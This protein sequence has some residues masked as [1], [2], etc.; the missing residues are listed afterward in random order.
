VTDADDHG[1][2]GVGP[3]GDDGRPRDEATPDR[4][5]ADAGEDGIALPDF[6]VD[7]FYDV[8]EGRARPLVTATE[9]ASALGC[10]QAESHD[11]L[12]RLAGEGRIESL[13]VETDPVVWYP[14]DWKETQ[15]RERVVVFPRRREAVVDRPSQFTRAQLSQFAHLVDTNREEGY[16][17]RVREAD[18][19]QAPH[20]TFE[21]L[22]R[23]MRQ[24]LGGR[25]DDLEGWVRDQWERARKF[26]LYTHEDGYVVLEAESAELLGNVA[27]PKLE[28]GTLRARISD[29]EA[30]VAE[31]KTAE[32]KRTLYE[33]GYPV[34]DDRHLDEGDALEIDVDLELRPYQHDWVSRFV[35]A[36]SGVL[37]GP[38]GS[39][40]TVAALGVMAA[41][42][43]E[44]LVLVPSR[45]LAEQ[46]R[47]EM[48]AHT[49]LTDEQI[50]L[51]HGGEKTIRPVTV[52]T[53]QTAG[54]DR[55]RMLFDERRWGLIVY[56]EVHHIPSPIHRRSADLQTKHR[57]GL[58]VDGDTILPVRRGGGVEMV[59]IED[60]ATEYL[61]NSVGVATVP[62]AETLGVTEKGE[63]EWTSLETVMRHEH[64]GPLFTVR[65]RNGRE[66]TVTQDHSLMVFDGERMEIRSK[67]PA[68][69]SD[70]DYLLQPDRIPKAAPESG[71]VDVL[72]LL[73]EGYVLVSEDAPK[74]VFDPLYEQDIG[75]NKSRYNWKSRRNLPLAIAREIGIDREHLKGVYVHG[76]HSYVPTE[77]PVQDFA[78]LV[79]LF[80][81]D[82]ALDKG[83]VEFYALDSTERSE[84]DEFERVIRK[85]CP[86]VDLGYVENGLNCTTIRVSGAL[87]DVFEAMGLENGA[88]EKSIPR[89]ILSNQAA[90]E[91]LVEGLVLGDG[92]TQRRERGREMVTVSTS[93]DRLAQGL[94]LV[95][96]GLGHVGGNYRRT[97][98]VRLREGEHDTV[99]NNLVRF[100]PKNRESGSRLSMTP[101]TSTLMT[102]Y[103]TI[104]R[105]QPNTADGRRTI[106]SSLRDRTRLNEGELLTLS[107]RSD[108]DA[109]WL[110]DA[111]VAMLEVESVTEAE[112]QEYVYDVST[113]LENF[114]GNHLFCHNSATPIR[115]DDREKEIFTLIGPPIGTD[116]EALFEAGYVAEPEVEI[117]L[118][119]WGSELHKNE[120]GSAEGHEKR[121]LAAMNPAKA[122]EV[123]AILGDH[124]GEKAL[125]FVEFIEQGERLAEALGV[126]F[127]SGE[128]PHARRRQ[129]FREFRQGPRDVLVVSRVGDEGIDLPNAELAIAASGLGGSRRQGAQRAGRTMRPVGRARMYVLA[130]RGSREEDFARQRMRHLAGKG[131]RVRETDSVAWSEGEST[132]RT[133][134]G[135]GGTGDGTG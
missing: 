77:V 105:Y 52:A 8:L 80:L 108:V 118:I 128:T 18:V 134:G 125:V 47:E 112:E 29:T 38:P 121:Q 11:A 9:V 135:T 113:G 14:A 2:T 21:G 46:W 24:A 44:T 117:R 16:L 98:E 55:H 13:D 4:T 79:G 97:P 57:I 122:E 74:S 6:A 90:Y 78:R 94:N 110:L 126:P 82:G 62:D 15:D 37:V 85:V 73:E 61:G 63:V 39:G 115:E 23:T 102:A 83:R 111:D 1:G 100:N 130:T 58:S 19:W 84:V 30:W 12:S 101:F 42:G 120:Y 124:P 25:Y 132:D 75:D 59:R 92:H 109:E 96:S 114:L 17:Y 20:E 93:S 36:K 67:L 56:D 91:G 50:G 22:S 103:E 89:S 26:R 131:V 116:W 53:Y 66:V 86:D 7:D 106:E 81:A 88:R 76:R 35:E 107:E 123:R 119:P 127:V 41:I 87:R 72:G 133:V 60:L 70:G 32:L 3:D 49:S 5:E 129:L 64:D 45:E 54:M 99:T 48:L 68:D 65:A 28:T 27:E 104:E 71:M 10:T 40:K 69:L 33:A 31:S 51:Y 34:R 95:L 43:G